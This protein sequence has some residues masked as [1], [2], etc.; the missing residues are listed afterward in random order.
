MFNL[1]HEMELIKIA[2]TEFETKLKLHII[3]S[4]NSVTASNPNITITIK[5]DHVIITDVIDGEPVDFNVWFSDDTTYI[6]AVKNGELVGVL[7]NED[8]STKGYLSMVSV[9][10]E[11]YRN[12]FGWDGS[13][14]I[15]QFM[16]V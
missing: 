4:I 8:E 2:V 12:Y 5:E 1:V 15:S 11:T 6:E 7:D 9:I 13:D 14:F 16:V 3:N 10:E